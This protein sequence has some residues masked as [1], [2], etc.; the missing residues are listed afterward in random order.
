ML[1]SGHHYLLLKS[2]DRLLR[3]HSSAEVLM[4][5]QLRDPC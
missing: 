5:A 1:L 2:K 3:G 4:K